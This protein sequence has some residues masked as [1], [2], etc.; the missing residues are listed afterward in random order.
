MDHEVWGYL[1][2]L[3]ALRLPKTNKK[4]VIKLSIFSANSSREAVRYLCA[5]EAHMSKQHSA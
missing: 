5:G 1:F 3:A 2:Q 4:R